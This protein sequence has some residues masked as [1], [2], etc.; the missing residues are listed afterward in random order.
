MIGEDLL[1]YEILP[2]LRPLECM[3]LRYI[4]KATLEYN[5]Q[6]FRKIFIELYLADRQYHYHNKD[7]WGTLSIQTASRDV[8]YLLRPNAKSTTNWS[9]KIWYNLADR[10]LSLG[11]LELLDDLST[12]SEFHDCIGNS[13]ICLSYRNLFD[14]RQSMPQL[15]NVYRSIRYLLRMHEFQQTKYCNMKDEI[16]FAPFVITVR[17]RQPY[18]KL[19]WNDPTISDYC[20][21]MALLHLLYGNKN[22]FNF[23]QELRMIVG[24][25]NSRARQILKEVYIPS[26]CRSED[27][28]RRYLPK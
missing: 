21:R 24:K 11:F 23:Q 20:T 16:G 27:I 25:K 9:Y 6:R 2:Y 19:V 1:I 13:R 28:V 17:D 8:R 26:K 7:C 15:C 3:E 14:L 5:I 22:V 18:T 10:I 4:C 12:L